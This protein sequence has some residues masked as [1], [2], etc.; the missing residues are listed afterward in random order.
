MTAISGWLDVSHAAD[1][2]GY[3]DALSADR[4]KRRRA[5]RAFLAWATRE[6]VPC[7]HRG[8][9]PVYLPADLDEA[10]GGAHRTQRHLKVVNG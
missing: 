6:G 5:E 4:E 1:H 7:G 8:R 3:A 2:V 9:R 10:L